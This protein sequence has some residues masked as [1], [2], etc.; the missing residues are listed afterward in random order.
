MHDLGE[1]LADV[2]GK[3]GFVRQVVQRPIAR[4]QGHVEPMHHAPLSQ[5]G[6]TTLTQHAKKIGSARAGVESFM[7]FVSDNLFEPESF[8][9]CWRKGPFSSKHVVDEGTV[10]PRLPR[11]GRLT[12]RPI[13]GL[14]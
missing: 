9:D 7:A 4:G 6:A 3:P 12:A 1:L 11:P 10:D 14:V 5:E 8:D 2:V 13:Y